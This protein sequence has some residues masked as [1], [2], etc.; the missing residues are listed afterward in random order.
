MCQIQNLP[1]AGN[2][3]DMKHVAPWSQ[4]R[5]ELIEWFCLNM[6]KKLN[7]LLA[8]PSLVVRGYASLSSHGDLDND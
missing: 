8:S 3:S 1:S 6:N 4:A 7:C 2:C 5:D